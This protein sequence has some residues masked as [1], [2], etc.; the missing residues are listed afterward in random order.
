M[1]SETWLALALREEDYGRAV[2]LLEEALALGHQTGS[3]AL[4]GHPLFGLG[5]AALYYGEHD[6]AAALI[7]ESL[8]LARGLGDHYLI[9]DCLWGMAGIAGAQGHAS[10]AVRLWGTAATLAQSIGIS[11]P[12]LR[13]LHERLLSTVRA[14]LDEEA[15]EA[16]FA[17]GR[18]TSMDEAVAYALQPP[19]GA[20]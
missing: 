7:R 11:T 19:S 10:R 17:K 6:R 3:P 12:N 5:L 18:A 2:S 1:P 9:K 15:F 16:E 20:E 14:Q 8:T 13:P 4:V